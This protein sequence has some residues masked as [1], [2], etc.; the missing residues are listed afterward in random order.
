VRRSG[1]A[2]QD[3]SL[4]ASGEKRPPEGKEAIMFLFIPPV[5]Q[6]VIGVVVL[7]AGVALHSVILDAVGGLGLVVGGARWLRKRRNGGAAR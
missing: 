7:G 3:G 2:A 5:I 1:G 4:W 6:A